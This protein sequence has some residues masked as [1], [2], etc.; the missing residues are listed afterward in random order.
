MGRGFVPSLSRLFAAELYGICGGQKI[1][2]QTSK[3][4]RQI[5]SFVPETERFVP[6]QTQ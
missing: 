3:N 2:R 5:T 4:K 6:Q 1:T